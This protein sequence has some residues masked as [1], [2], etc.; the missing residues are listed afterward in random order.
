MNEPW[1]GA[2]S[3]RALTDAHFAI[4]AETLECEIAAIRAVWEVE[5]AG[6]HFRPDGGVIRRFEPH[7]FP[8]RHWP[9][10]NF[11][12]RPGQAPWRASLDQSSDAMFRKAAAIDLEAACRA[13]SWGAPQIMGFNHAAAGFE[14]A[15]GMVVAMAGG[16]P[17]Q[18]AAFVA[19]IRD[20]GLA[21]AIRGHDWEAFARRYN[22]S[23]QVA[24]YARRM[25]AA[26][27]RLSGTPSPVVLRVGDRGAAV[28]TLQGALD[29]A[30]D[31]IF[32]PETLAA[33]RRFQG[34]AGL[35]VDG[36]MGARSWAALKQA[37]RDVTPP[38]QDTPSE[39]LVDQVKGWAAAGG[40]VSA[41]LAGLTTA[42]PDAA[43]L[44]LV[45][46]AVVLAVMAG[47]AWAWRQA[48]A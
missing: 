21:P 39:A 14:S 46:G 15:T 32:G 48:T 38:P 37:A 22:G 24:V 8:R 23:G 13:T 47:A 16:A 43:V 42:L 30:E 45:S 31:G 1:K 34:E 6:Q 27:R 3:P 10:L 11:A 29:I 33:V 7:H 17:A 20:W 40:A 19:L 18:L 36:I 41:A 28:R 25:E 2:A 12:P 5:A 35:P 44:V 4:A 9:A 26:W